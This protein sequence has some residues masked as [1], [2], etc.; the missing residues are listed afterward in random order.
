MV[1]R[2]H[3]HVTTPQPFACFMGGMTLQAHNTYSA[4]AVLITELETKQQLLSFKNVTLL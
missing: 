2:L 4:I 1:I 3:S